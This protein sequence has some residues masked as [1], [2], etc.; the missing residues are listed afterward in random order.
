[1]ILLLLA[2]GPSEKL[3]GTV[4]FEVAAEVSGVEGESPPASEMDVGV[5]V[6]RGGDEVLLVSDVVDIMIPKR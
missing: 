6:C 1:M 4:R 5:A 3:P 2:F